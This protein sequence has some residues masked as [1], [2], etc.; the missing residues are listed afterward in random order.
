VQRGNWH[1]KS[2]TRNVSPLGSLSSLQTLVLLLPELMSWQ[3]HSALCRHV[4]LCEQPP[5]ND[6]AVKSDISVITLKQWW[7][8]IRRL[9]SFYALLSD[10][11]QGEPHKTCLTRP[12]RCDINGIQTITPS[13]C[14]NCNK[15]PTTLKT[16][17]RKRLTEHWT[18]DSKCTR[19]IR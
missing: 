11:K 2:R 4:T 3:L 12:L 1:R 18:R 6:R 9:F 8:W 14:V 17:Q 15:Q 7:V 5:L 16:H 10:I 13:V 19:G